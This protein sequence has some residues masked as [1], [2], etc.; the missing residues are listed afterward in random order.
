MLSRDQRVGFFFSSRRRHTSW[1]RDWSS[2]VCSS[3]LFD[4]RPQRVLPMRGIDDDRAARIETETVKAMSGDMTGEM[5]AETAALA[6]PVLAQAV[7]V[8]DMDWRDED[9]FFLPSILPPMWRRV[10]GRRN[11]ASQHSRCKAEGSRQCG[12]RRRIVLMETG[13]TE[14]AIGQV[15]IK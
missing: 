14:T 15:G 6:Q 11:K 8:P 9:D 12:L 10:G 1:P 2:D 13:T 3:D 4:Q 7:L 5:T